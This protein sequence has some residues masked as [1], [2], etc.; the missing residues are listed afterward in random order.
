MLA[1]FLASA[2]E[3]EMIGEAPNCTRFKTD[4]HVITFLQALQDGRLWRDELSPEIPTHWERRG[5]LV[6]LPQ[7]AFVSP[8]WSEIELWDEVCEVLG[9]QRLAR[10]SEINDDDFRSPNVVVLK[11]ADTWVSHVDNGI[12]YQWDIAR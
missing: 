6:L 9:C 10:K 1:L 12:E 4:A 2:A 8:V 11:G 7:T 3:N 5:D